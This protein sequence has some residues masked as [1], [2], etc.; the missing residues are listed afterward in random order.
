MAD[1][2]DQTWIA[3]LYQQNRRPLFLTAWNILRCHSLAEDAVHSAFARLAAMPS[4][5]RDPKLYVFRAVRNAA[6]DIAKLRG[7]RRERPY[8]E[9]PLHF[10]PAHDESDEISAAVAAALDELDDA[11]REVI[12]L[13]LH[14]RLTF[15]E[16]SAVLEQPLPTVASRYRRALEKLR[17]MLEVCHE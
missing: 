1:M 11:S 8:L 3:E 12:E 7:R 10:C 9:E 16:I 15:L 17:C 4:P 6:L 14:A 13:H 2:P 5:P